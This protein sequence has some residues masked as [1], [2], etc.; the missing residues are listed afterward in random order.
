MIPVIRTVEWHI[1]SPPYH[2]KSNGQAEVSV[3][4]VKKLLKKLLSE[5]EQVELDLALSRAL[6]FIRTDV[7]IRKGTSPAELFLGRKIRSRLSVLSKEEVKV[8]KVN[9][10]YVNNKF[11][12]DETVKFRW[13]TNNHPSWYTGK[14]IK[15][16]GRNVYLIKQGDSEKKVH[17]NYI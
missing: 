4:E 9:G 2:P 7:N 13:I 12:V 1:P 8:S 11:K 3:R 17:Q 16:L 5:N 15:I 10:Q 14:I 6:F